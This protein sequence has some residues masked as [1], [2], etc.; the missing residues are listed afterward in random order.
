MS[1]SSLL[2]WMQLIR[3]TQAPDRS[4]AAAAAIFCILFTVLCGPTSGH[5]YSQFYFLIRPVYSKFLRVFEPA[6]PK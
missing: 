4:A 2:E 1:Q 5:I 3:I 6:A